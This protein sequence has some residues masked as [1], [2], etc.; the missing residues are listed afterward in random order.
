[1]I[2]LCGAGAGESYA[3]RGL[4]LNVAQRCGDHD[5]RRYLVKVE[6]FQQFF[7]RQLDVS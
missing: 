7:A 2:H 4:R 6:S 5:V 1:V 3:R